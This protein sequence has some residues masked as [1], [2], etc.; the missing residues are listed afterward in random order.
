MESYKRLETN[1]NALLDQYKENIDS[2]HELQH[3]L[4]QDILPSL[5]DEL[6][7]SQELQ[8]FAKDWLADTGMWVFL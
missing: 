6:G 5:S 8:D 7:L 1:K 4:I 2:V 3:T